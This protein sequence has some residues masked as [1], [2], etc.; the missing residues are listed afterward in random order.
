MG[1]GFRVPML[2]DPRVVTSGVIS[3]IAM[4]VNH[5]RG[6]ITP[7]YNYPRTSKCRRHHQGTLVWERLLE[8]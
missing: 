8:R 6:L 4:A 5:I 1:L 7:T 2:G 3:R